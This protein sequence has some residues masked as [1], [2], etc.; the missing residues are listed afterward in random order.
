MEN[1]IRQVGKAFIIRE[2]C[3]RLFPNYIEINLSDDH[4]RNR[5]SEN[6]QTVGDFYLQLSAIAGKR[7]GNNTDTIVFLDEIQVY[8]EL[9]S[10]LKPLSMKFISGEEI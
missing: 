2:V 7:L 10:L 6:V 5:Y 1:A 9:L 3:R 8:L 4:R